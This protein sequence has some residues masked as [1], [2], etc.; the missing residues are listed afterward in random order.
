LVE[1]KGTGFATDEETF[2][3]NPERVRNGSGAGEGKTQ[4]EPRLPD[5]DGRLLSQGPFQNRVRDLG[6]LPGPSSG[7]KTGNPKEGQDEQV[8]LGLFIFFGDVGIGYGI[9][10]DKKVIFMICFIYTKAK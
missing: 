9:R 4:T 1:E 3:R 10:K 5:E 7:F 8:I 2:R 6:L